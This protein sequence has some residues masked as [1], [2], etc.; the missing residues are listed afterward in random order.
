MITILG[1]GGAIAS[2]LVP[3]L[4]DHGEPIR[5]VGRHPRIRP[6][7]TELVAADLTDRDA[8]VRAVA[9]SRIVFLVVGLPY[10]VRVWQELWPRIMRNTMEAVKQAGARLVFFDNVYMYGSV[11]GPM[12][13]ETPFR[14]T[15]RKGELR[16][17]IATMLL[18]EIHSGSLTALIARSADFYGPNARNGVPNVLVI[19]RLARGQRALWPVKDTAKHSLTFTPDA[20]RGLMLLAAHEG[21]WNQTWHLPT[22]PDPP[23]GRQ[24]VEL[25]AGA[26]G[27]SPRYRVLSR[28]MVWAGGWLDRTVRETKEMLYQ[29]D[30]D[31]LF[32][33]T[34]FTRTFGA[35]A[36]PYVEGA[37]RCA[38]A[39]A[40]PESPS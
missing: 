25:A 3:L 23:T 27:V 26:L 28:P 32:D 9:G 38:A 31:Y 35:A 8:T 21:A 33:A 36:T 20:A 10:D 13:E 2:E 30:R 11:D 12:T 4:V 6:G 19:D 16:A 14:P 17:A 22:A 1:A 39:T 34:K 18:D 7:A 29:Y 40:P 37:R 5:L 15:S 24:F